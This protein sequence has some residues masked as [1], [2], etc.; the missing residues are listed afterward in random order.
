MD[1]NYEATFNEEWEKYK[2]NHKIL[3]NIMILGRTGVGKSSLINTIFKNYIAEVSDLVP[4]TQDFKVFRG[5]EYGISVN[6]I[7]SKGYEIND[8][9]DESR[10]AMESFVCKIQNYIAEAYNN[11]QKVHLIWYCIPITEE[12]VEPLDKELIKRLSSIESIRGRIA[13]IL[14]KC[15]EDDEDCTTAKAFKDVLKGLNIPGLQAFETSNDEGIEADLD[16]LIRWSIDS[17]DDE[18]LKDNFISAQQGSLKEKRKRAKA[19]INKSTTAATLVAVSPIPHDSLVLIPIQMNMIV[20]IINIYGISGMAAISKNV[21]S[22]I[23]ISSVGKSLAASL[24]KVIPIAGNIVNAAV[25]ASI[26]KALGE[27]ISKICREAYKDS[28]AGKKIQWDRLF[29]AS[30]VKPVVESYFREGNRE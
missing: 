17:L 18:D 12:R 9:A 3:P 2:E 13:V 19:I 28:L 11:A 1:N 26:T 29:D 30:V 25:A 23:V 20:R 27:A 21:I 24:V 7:D 14:T 10:E 8:D 6:L 4:E 5:E 16:K 15:D 22:D